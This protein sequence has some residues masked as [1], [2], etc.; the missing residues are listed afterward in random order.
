MKTKNKLSTRYVFQIGFFLSLFIFYLFISLF[1]CLCFMC[2][3]QHFFSHI[4]Q[5]LDHL[6]GFP[7]ITI[8][9]FFHKCQTL[10]TIPTWFLNQWWETITLNVQDQLSQRNNTSLKDQTSI[11]NWILSSLSL[12]GTLHIGFNQGWRGDKVVERQPS[13]LCMQRTPIWALLLSQSCLIF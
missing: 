9:Q 7:G 2:F 13:S 5:R 12:S 6:T 10:I 11:T 8:L 3:F 4:R 1:V